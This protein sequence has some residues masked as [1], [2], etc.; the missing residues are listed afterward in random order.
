MLFKLTTGNQMVKK[1]LNI[2]IGH[3]QKL[4]QIDTSKKSVDKSKILEIL[5]EA[6][7]PRLGGRLK[8]DDQHSIYTFLV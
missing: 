2:A 6:A 7:S 5:D 8:K 1:I 4:P 3:D